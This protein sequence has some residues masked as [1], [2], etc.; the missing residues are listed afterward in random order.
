MTSLFDIEISWWQLPRMFVQI[1]RLSVWLTHF[2]SNR[3]NYSQYPVCGFLSLLMHGRQILIN[4][5][6]TFISAHCYH[7]LT[8]VEGKS[9]IYFN[10][11]KN[12][13]RVGDIWVLLD[14]PYRYAIIGSTSLSV[15]MQYFMNF[16]KHGL[17]I[18]RPLV[19]AF[20]LAVSNGN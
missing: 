17:P 2:L 20:F 15:R 3:T 12:H 19:P 11:L 8:Q 7:M 6:C 13:F 5:V 1:C 14:S 10:F 9:I 18:W 4:T 16:I